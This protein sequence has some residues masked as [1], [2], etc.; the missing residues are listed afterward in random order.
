VGAVGSSPVGAVGS[1]GSSPVGTVGSS[2]VGAVGSVGSSSIGSP[3]GG[4]GRVS[5]VGS[6]Y[7]TSGVFPPSSGRTPGVYSWSGVSTGAGT[8]PSAWGINIKNI[9]ADRNPMFYR[10]LGKR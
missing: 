6:T 4:V 1:V 5:G 7:I 9:Y 2:P 8:N 10:T 3:V